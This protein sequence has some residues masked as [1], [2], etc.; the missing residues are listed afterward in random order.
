MTNKKHDT[1]YFQDHMPGNICFGCGRDNHDGLKISS[2]WDGD[3]AICQW[4][5]EDKYQ[6]WKGIMNGGILATIIDCHSMCTAM[7][8]A[9]KAESRTLD[10]EPIYRYATGTLKVKYIKPTPNDVLVTLRA[11]IVE[12]KGRKVLVHCK[13]FC[14]DVLTAEADVVAIQVYNSAIQSEG[15][16]SSE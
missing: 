1:D 6:G 4:K 12:I 14:E 3:E 10:S 15:I 2:Y 13:V 16:F 8:S 5:S 9:Y 11:S 7:A